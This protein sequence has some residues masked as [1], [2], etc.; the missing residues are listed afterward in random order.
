MKRGLLLRG[1]ALVLAVAALLLGLQARDRA[2]HRADTAAALEDRAR[3]ALADDRAR[4]AH[5]RS[6]LAAARAAVRD[7]GAAANGA[8]SA[9]GTIVDA[10]GALTDRL[11]RLQAAGAAEDIDGYNRIVDELRAHDGDLE[12]ATR[13]I[14]APFDEYSSALGSLP[15]ARCAGPRRASIAWVAYG[16]SGLQCARLAVPLDD[17]APHGARIELTVVR[18][19]ADDP[20]RDLG[21]L[22]INPGGP[23][24]SAIAALRVASLTLPDEVLRRFDLI[25]VDP[26]GV[27]QSTPVDCADDL[28]PLFANGLVDADVAVRRRALRAVEQL[29]Q[30]CA[31][32][33]GDLLR[34]LD[35]VSTARDLDRVRAALGVDRIS[36]LGFS[37]GTYLGSVYAELFPH[38]L[39]AAILDGGVAPDHALDVATLTPGADDVGDALRDALTQCSSDSTCPFNSAGNAGAAYDALMQRLQEHPLAVGPRTLGRGL[40]ELGVVETVY[41]GREERP[42]LM[43]ALAHA[44]LGDGA[45]LLALSDSYTGRRKDGSYSNEL[46]ANEAVSCVEVSGRPSRHDAERRIARLGTLGRLDAIGL[47][48]ELP[49]AFWPAPVVAHPL[50]HLDGAG[51]PPILVIG[52]AGDAITPIAG[53]RAL[54]DAL[55]SG[56]LLTYQGDG[57][58]VVGRGNA[59]VD[60]AVVTY[61]VDGTAPAD[62][63]TCP[64]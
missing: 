40:A 39:R 25:G 3:H 15:T 34:H 33:S 26:R 41:G 56:R 37:Y 44:A 62:G 2:E 8:V 17:A 10:E 42:Q 55:D 46:E 59:C 38:H 30:G 7:F 49:C 43:T 35:T 47:M 51:A 16:A 13:G 4:L 48:L 27:G 24:L 21:P 57:H 36:Y 31:T 22:F 29:V 58:T 20:Q 63:A 9:G 23:G 60:L 5:T 53:A 12:A 6:D 61:L 54:A 11:A 52:N 45:P 19:P 32:R 64:A 28:D 18:R 50:R 1:C 14:E